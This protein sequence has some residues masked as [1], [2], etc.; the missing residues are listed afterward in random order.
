MIAV[1]G[2]CTSPKVQAAPAFKSGLQKSTEQSCRVTP[3]KPGRPC[4]TAGAQRPF[5]GSS[6]CAK[7]EMADGRCRPDFQRAVCAARAKLKRRP[8]LPTTCLCC[9]TRA[10]ASMPSP[11]LRTQAFCILRIWRMTALFSFV[12][13]L[14]IPVMTAM[15]LNC[16]RQPVCPTMQMQGQL[17]QPASIPRKMPSLAEQVISYTFCCAGG[18]KP[19]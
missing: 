4:C 3:W 7:E 11:P 17:S 18:P 14:A 12:H 19:I 1:A 13:R 15:H 16:M 2:C 9:R 5:H 6:V 8:L 10:G